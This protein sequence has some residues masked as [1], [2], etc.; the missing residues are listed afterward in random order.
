V[1]NTR[2]GNGYALSSSRVF[3]LDGASVDL[4]HLLPPAGDNHPADTTSV[5]FAFNSHDPSPLPEVKQVI[6]FT[7]VGQ[8][9]LPVQITAMK[10]RIVAQRPPFDGT[11]VYI[12]PQGGSA[13]LALGFDLDS[14]RLDARLLTD[15]DPNKPYI[16]DLHQGPTAQ[17][18]FDH[19][20]VTLSRDERVTFDPLIFKSSISSAC[21]CEFVVDVIFSDGSVVTVD[22]NG[23]P[24]RIS[25]FAQRY[26]RSYFVNLCTNRYEK[27][28]GIFDCK[29]RSYH[30]SCATP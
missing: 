21:Q 17:N 1:E 29:E 3:E 5:V 19:M 22:N 10:A 7:L 28:D 4:Q 24:W 2:S 18:Y 13:S 6:H 30:P 15:K 16:D 11:L 8:H 26:K 25:G 9:Y 14:N 23:L 12:A 20:Q 27:C